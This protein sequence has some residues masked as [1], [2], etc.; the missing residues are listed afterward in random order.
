MGV[1]VNRVCM[2]HTRLSG[3]QLGMQ[4]KHSDI[5]VQV[6]TSCFVMNGFLYIYTCFKQVSIIYNCLK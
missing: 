6:I 3:I 1:S 2:W 4:R 5:L